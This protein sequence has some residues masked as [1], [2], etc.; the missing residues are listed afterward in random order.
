V[1]ALQQCAHCRGAF[2]KSRKKRKDKAN[3][4]KELRGLLG[5]IHRQGREYMKH[6]PKIVMELTPGEIEAMLRYKKQRDAGL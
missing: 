4:S 2:N 6:R 5:D 1:D 3:S